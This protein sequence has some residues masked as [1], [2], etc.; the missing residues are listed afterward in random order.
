LLLPT[1]LMNLLCAIDLR[2]GQAVRLVQGDFGRER[3]FGNP[4]ELADRYVEEGA[5]HLHVVDLDAARTGSPVNRHVVKAIIDRVSVPVQVGG[6]ART[7]RDVAELVAI[8][9]DRVVMGTVALK[10]PEV[11]HAWPSRFPGRIVLG[12]D[13]R[14][15]D[16][17]ALEPAA[18]GWVEGGGV[19]M[20]ELLEAWR[21]EP[22][23]AIV[24]TSIDRDGTE[25]GPDL[26][27]L[28]SVLDTSDHSVV[29]S[30]GV[31]SLDDLRAL[32]S[33]RSP[34]RD[35][36]LDGVVVGKALVDGTLGVREAVAA[37]APSA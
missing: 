20:A 21:D 8:G 10:E 19:T 23:A 25:S 30:G 31:G 37:C 33:L 12:L 29:A 32:A 5:T 13:Y 27:A 1:L 35:R 11:A 6:G 24:M 34:V 14:R 18:S 16:D 2:A 36:A 26:A 28:L 4:L 3:S 7:D 15:R 9:A 17:G 22:I